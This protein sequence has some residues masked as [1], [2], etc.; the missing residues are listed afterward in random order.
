[1]QML[2]TLSRPKR[3]LQLILAG[4]I[5]F[6]MAWLANRKRYDDHLLLTGID[7][8]D[9]QQFPNKVSQLILFPVHLLVIAACNIWILN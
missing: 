6:V 5:I 4:L 1:M 2:R 7:G 3:I 8:V 9:G